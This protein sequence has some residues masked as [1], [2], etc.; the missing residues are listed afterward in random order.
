MAGRYCDL[1]DEI[2]HR[3]Y[4][5]T[6]RHVDPKVIANTLHLPLKTVNNLITRINTPD[7]SPGMEIAENGVKENSV[8]E[9]GFLDVYYYQKTRFALIKLV[10]T[11]NE[12]NSDILNKEL[13][14]V[15][16]SF[17][18]AAAIK[19]SDVVSMD[20]AASRNL[21][22]YN[23]IFQKDSKFLAILDPSKAI[24]PQLLE[25]QLEGAIPIFGT[26]RAFEEA[27]F[28]RQLLRPPRG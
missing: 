25:F 1:S 17:Y 18:K 24:E 8:P 19:M 11:L 26:E 28:P 10:G 12:E 16:G 22:D 20:E 13:Q 4:R 6:K 27:A 5:L 7:P 23:E 3:L 15:L 2:Y 9:I 21:L 14:K